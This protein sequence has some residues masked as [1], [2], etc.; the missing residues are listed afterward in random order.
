MTV[1]YYTKHVY[2]KPMHYINDLGTRQSV[3]QLTGKHTIDK[4]DMAA[5]ADL[6]IHCVEVLVGHE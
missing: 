1:E 3:T 2:G 6:N 4:K 5:L